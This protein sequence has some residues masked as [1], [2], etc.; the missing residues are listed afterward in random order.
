LVL[1]SFSVIEPNSK[2]T[3]VITIFETEDEE[4]VGV[5]KLKGFLSKPELVGDVMPWI[6]RAGE[7]PVGRNGPPPL[8]LPPP[9]P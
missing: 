3:W 4:D 6:E 9:P 7:K 2:K 1:P 8:L 5:D